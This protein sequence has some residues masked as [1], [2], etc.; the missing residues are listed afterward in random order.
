MFQSLYMRPNGADDKTATVPRN[1]LVRGDARQVIA[2]GVCAI[3]GTA[4]AFAVSLSQSNS[5]FS[6]RIITS[7]E[8]RCNMCIGLGSSKKL[9]VRNWVSKVLC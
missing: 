5:H 3:R 4:A 1:V 6:N 9:I 2:E 7:Y 8:M